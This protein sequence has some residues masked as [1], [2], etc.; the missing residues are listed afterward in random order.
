VSAPFDRAGTDS[1]ETSFSTFTNDAP[2]DP[3]RSARIVLEVLDARGAVKSRTRIDRLPALIGRGYACDL[4]VDDPYVDAVHVRLTED[5]AGAIVAEDAGSVN[6]MRA[7]A[8]EFRPETSVHVVPGLELRIGR[9]RIRCCDPTQ[10]VAPTLPDP[11]AP[12]R[13]AGVAEAPPPPRWLDRPLTR[14]GVLALG[15]AIVLVH[16]YLGTAERTNA[17]KI[18]GEGIGFLLMTAV[19]AGAWA[20][21]GRLAAA[22]RPAFTSH[23][24]IAWAVMGILTVV[25]IADSWLKFLWPTGLAAPALAG[26]A[27]LA[28]AIAMLT[29]H[30]AVASTMQP[31]KRV[32]VSSAIVIAMLA[33]GAL[34][35]FA[36]DDTF[37][38]KLEI[39]GDLEP[40]PARYIPAERITDFASSV[41]ELQKKADDE[42]AKTAKP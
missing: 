30:L 2:R 15:M 19:W 27:G 38:S 16:T 31:A 34:I 8:P 18:A 22:H 35:S 10:A 24:A 29:Q 21:G 12:S 37:S 1:P 42:A 3:H 13:R 11:T 14:Y 7:G 5:A 20:L 39:A 9:T 41:K 40:I 33:I 25:G 4:I 32:K 17:A 26:I 6:G 23:L 36:N 28:I